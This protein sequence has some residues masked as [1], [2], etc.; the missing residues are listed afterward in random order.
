RLRAS[1]VSAE[2]ARPQGN[3][4][5]LLEPKFGLPAKVRFCTRCVIS[6]QRPSSA[7]EYQHTTASPKETIHFDEEGVCAACRFAEMKDTR[8][9]WKERERE[10]IDLLARHRRTDGRFDVLVPGSGGKDSIYAAH[11]L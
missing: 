2:P 7:V 4:V 5:S 9:D 8:V 1:N 3:A 10:L 6:N 11:L